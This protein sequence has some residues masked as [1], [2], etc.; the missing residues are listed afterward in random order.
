LICGQER[1][2][3]VNINVEKLEACGISPLQV[4]QSVLTSN[5]D[6]P[7]GSVKTNNQDILVRLSGKFRDVEELRNLVIM[8]SST[9]GQIRLR[10]IAD[11]QD[12][13]KDVEKIARVNQDNALILQ[14]LK[15]SDANAVKVSEGIN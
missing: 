2:I 15:Q 11:V 3:P 13:Q 14:V 7:T 1:G 9:G 8:S 12:T 4:T 10:D 5:L 6:F